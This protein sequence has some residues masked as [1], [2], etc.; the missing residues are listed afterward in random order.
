MSVAYR[1]EICGK[2]YLGSSKPENCPYCGAHQK[3]LK[4]LENYSRAMPEEITEKSRKNV[5]K[6]R[7]GDR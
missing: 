1:C 2:T 5:L 4:K 3:Y 7:I 6:A